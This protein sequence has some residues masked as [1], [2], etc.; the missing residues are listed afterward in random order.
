[1]KR[2]SLF[3]AFA[4]GIFLLVFSALPLTISGAYG[5]E[6]LN[7]VIVFPGGPAVG[8]E[9]KKF[10]NQFIEAIGKQT[11][12]NASAM[13]GEYFNDTKQVEKYI[14]SNSNAFIMGSIGFF[15]SK[16]ALFNLQPLAIVNIEGNSQEEY[17]ILVKKGRYKSLKD[18]QGK[19]LAGSVLFEDDKFINTIAFNNKLDIKKY[20]KLKPTQR[21]LS[22]LRKVASDNMDSVILNQ[23]QY[24]SLK[25][26]GSLFDKLE[27]VH[28]S[29]AVPALG[30]MMVET[31]KT[32]EVKDAIIKSVAGMCALEEGKPVCKNF[33][34][35][36]FEIVQPGALNEVIKRFDSAK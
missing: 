4:T 34:I 28:K 12:M 26:L 14:K 5:A 8:E 36:G 10:I 17:Y 33:G 2:N 35:S 23:M 25:R 27:I 30:M 7:F 15:L 29:Q 3:L 16:R 31:K 19:Q 24:Q 9:G 11:G 18:L 22:E 20:F 32:L 6:K 1:M 21:P 13:Q